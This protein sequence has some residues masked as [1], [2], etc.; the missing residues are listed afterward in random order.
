MNQNKH[1]N[2]LLLTLL[3]TLIGFGSIPAEAKAVEKFI[4]IGQLDWMTENVNTKTTSSYCYDGKEANCDKYGRLYSWDAARKVCPD[5][6]H[7]PSLAEW[8]TLGPFGNLKAEHSWEA[9]N[10]GDNIDFAGLAAGFRNSKGKF[11]LLGK[12]G[13]FWTSDETDSQKANYC[14]LSGKSVDL[15]CNSYSKQGAMSVRC[16]RAAKRDTPD[17]CYDTDGNFLGDETCA[18]IMA[19]ASGNSG[20]LDDEGEVADDKGYSAPSSN[21]KHGPSIK[22]ENLGVLGYIILALVI[23][24]LIAYIFVFIKSRKDQELVFFIGG[25][26]GLI[27]T[28]A[29]WII[30]MIDAIYMW[31]SASSIG[32]APIVIAVVMGIGIIVSIVLAA[33]ASVGWKNRVMSVYGHLYTVIVALLIVL[34]IVALFLGNWASQI[35][36]NRKGERIDG[37]IRKNDGHVWVDSNDIFSVGM[38][39]LLR[40]LWGFCKDFQL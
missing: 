23:I 27:V 13:D 37:P 11:E 38:R 2:S 35:A 39:A 1:A 3:L 12:R 19:M 26:T 4:T 8:K 6:W 32:A 33:K 28:L 20:N 24:S 15:A 7:L 17:E 40:V 21:E 5:G 29:A 34:T 9:G 31:A 22:S 30:L 25:K 14:Y 10:G 36:V 16:V 18:G